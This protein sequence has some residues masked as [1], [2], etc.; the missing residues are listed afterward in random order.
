MSYSCRGKIHKGKEGISCQQN[1][2]TGSSH[3]YILTLPP[4]YRERQRQVDRENRDRDR[5]IE[6]ETQ[7]E[8]TYKLIHPP[9]P[10]S[11]KFP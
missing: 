8:N 9:S 11:L 6:R 3:L 1:Q 4:T 2:G 10:S 7:R 5:E